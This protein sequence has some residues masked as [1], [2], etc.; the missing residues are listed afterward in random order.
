MKITSEIKKKLSQ[1]A[2]KYNLKLIILF[3]SFASGKTHKESDLDIAIQ[4]KREPGSS[5]FNDE[6]ALIGEFTKI[7]NG[8]KV[9]LC[10]INRANPLLLKQ[11]NQ[12]CVLLYGDLSDFYNFKIY[13]FNRYNDYKI[14]FKME[15]DFVKKQVKKINS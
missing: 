1:I 7:F 12:N 10:L 5:A 14:Y 15:S 8:K 13:A 11:I 4:Y 3:G 2:K 6:L 9:D